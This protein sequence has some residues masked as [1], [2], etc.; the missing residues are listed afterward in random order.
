MLRIEHLEVGAVAV[1]DLEVA[2]GACV[3]LMGPSGAGKSML[4]RAIVD[5]DPNRAAVSLDGQDRAAMSAPQWRR[6]VGYVPAEPAWWAERAGDHFTDADRVKPLMD[7]LGLPSALLEAPVA[8][9]STGER[10]RFALIRALLLEPR[11]LLLDE[12][13]AALDAKSAVAAETLLKELLDDGVAV[14][15][16][17]HDADQAQRLAA[18]TLHMQAGRILA[19][20]E[21]VEAAS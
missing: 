7:R 16:V 8:Q 17:T 6:R 13:T 1:R 14:L 3:A 19:P 18:R 9:L 5:L 20:G 21:A 2:G 15:I 12:P 10:Q 11:A 4:L